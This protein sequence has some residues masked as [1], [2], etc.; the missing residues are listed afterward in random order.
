VKQYQIE[1]AFIYK[2]F[3]W[4]SEFH[5]KNIYDNFD[6]SGTDLGGFY[7]AAG[8]FPSQVL[9][10]WPEPLEIATRY[11]VVRPDLQINRNK[12]REVALGFNWFF[13]EHKNKLT[14]EITRFTFEDKELSQDDELRFRLQ[15]DIS[16]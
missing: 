6:E 10:F 15:L 9:G 13:A 8:Y 4:A 2:G 1:T 14:T 16:F 7:I 5:R 11:A 12:Q 3:S